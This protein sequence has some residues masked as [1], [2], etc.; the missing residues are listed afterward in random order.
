MVQEGSGRTDTGP[1]LRILVVL[2][3]VIAALY[4]ASVL[5]QLGVQFADIILIFFLAWLLAFTLSPI[6]RFIDRHPRVAWGQAVGLVYVGLLLVVV[7]GGV[8]FLPV[9]AGQLQQIG[10]ALP[11]YAEGLPDVFR[12]VQDWLDARSIPLELNTLY[13]PLIGRAE[14][15][16]TA[17]AQNALGLAQ[18]IALV[19]FDMVLILILSF[20]I[21]L[22][23]ER[24]TQG[25]IATLPLRYRAN[26]R[27]FLDSIDRTFGGFIRGSAIMALVYGIGTA[28]VM[29]IQGLPFVLPV[30]AFAG[31]VVIIPFIGSF[32]AIIP[33]IF[34]AALTGDVTKLV[35]VL[36]LLLILQQIV[37]NV[38]APKLLAEHVGLHPL[39]VFLAILLGAK[40]AGIWGVLFGVPVMAVIYSMAVFFYRQRVTEETP[41]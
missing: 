10:G 5:W 1:W 29:W 19:I 37:L 23:G 31:L 33:P 40:V 36:I 13:Q 38:V 35:V 41:S 12:R 30:S 14:S 8:L 4:L 6:A 15:I 27:F 3:I 32:I 28:F 25:F 11:T 16:G 2:L 24:F 9:A 17:I 20:Y 39:F 7:L 22:D 26:A 18:G 21:M 34:L